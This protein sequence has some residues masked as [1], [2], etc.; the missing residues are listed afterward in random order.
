MTPDELGIMDNNNCVL[1][2]RG[3][4]PFFCTKYPLEKHPGYKLSGDANDKYIFDVQELINTGEKRAKPQPEKE[5]HTV[6]LLKN[7]EKADTRES[8]RLMRMNA[9]RRH[10]KSVRGQDIGVAKTLKEGVDELISVSPQAEIARQQEEDYLRYQR[11][12]EKEREKQREEEKQEPLFL[13][14]DSFD[15][16]E[17]EVEITEPVYNFPPAVEIPQRPEMD[18]EPFIENMLELAGGS[19]IPT[20]AEVAYN[21]YG[22][23][24]F[25]NDDDFNFDLDSI[26]L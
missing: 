12:L 6:E 15:F 17:P 25:V 19:P 20:G 3:E 18:N 10:H 26:Y 23:N 21:M 24:E 9:Q 1:F 4:Y 13:L 8:E 7:M 22:D 11:E 14:D 2:I 5:A 16:N